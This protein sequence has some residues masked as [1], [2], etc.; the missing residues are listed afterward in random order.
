[1]FYKSI[2]NVVVVAVVSAVFCIGC[3]VDPDDSNNPSV[4]KGTFTD[5]RDGQT[6]NWVTI[7]GKTWMAE[8]L[9]YA[10][11]GSKCYE[12]NPS[13]C[14][15]YGRLYDWATALT[16]CPSGW[17][18]PTA[19]EWTALEDYVEKESD[20]RI[21]AGTKLKSTV[22]W[23]DYRGS[24]GNGTDDFGFSTLPGGTGGPNGDFSDS[25]YWGNWWSASE[26]ISSSYGWSRNMSFN[27]GNV[28]GG[29]GSKAYLY[30][31]RCVQN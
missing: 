14:A 27:Y 3:V 21:C 29:N 24:S 30:S 4:K 2:L 25:G 16:A 5:S 11:E 8:N 12:D 28:G 10:A 26:G 19:A 13:N 15:T 22:G 7:S 17:H 1:M 18:L 20:C 6:Y 9:N 31:V 23:N